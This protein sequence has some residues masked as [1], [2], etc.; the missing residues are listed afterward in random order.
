MALGEIMSLIVLLVAASFPLA[1]GCSVWRVFNGEA[2]N[3]LR[4]TYA[5]SLQ[6]QQSQSDQFLHRCGGTL[7][8]R[9]L[10]LTA[11]HCVWLD[12]V[13][14]ETDFRES[15]TY[16]GNLSKPLYAAVA[17]SCRHEEGWER[18]SVVRYYIPPTYWGVEPTKR[19][20]DI[21]VLV[22]ERDVRED[23]YPVIMQ[24]KKQPQNR[25]NSDEVVIIG[26]GAQNEQE[27]QNQKMYAENMPHLKS[28]NFQLIECDNETLISMG[29]SESSRIDFDKSMLC[30]VSDKTDA[31]D[32]CPGDSGGPLLE[33]H[34]H[35]PNQD[36]QIAVSMWAPNL[37]CS[38]ASRKPSVFTKVG[39]W[40]EAIQRIITRES[41]AA[42]K[43]ARTLGL[44]DPLMLPD[45]EHIQLQPVF[46]PADIF[47]QN[48]FA[49]QGNETSTDESNY[50]N[51]N[52]SVTN[53]Q[54]SLYQDTVLQNTSVLNLSTP[55]YSINWY[56]EFSSNNLYEANQTSVASDNTQYEQ[57]EL[58]EFRTRQYQ[59]ENK[60]SQFSTLFQYS[61]YQNDAEMSVSGCNNSYLDNQDEDNL[62]EPEPENESL[63]SENVSQQYENQGNLYQI[64][65]D[66]YNRENISQLNVHNQNE[67]NIYDFIQTSVIAQQLIQQQINQ[68]QAYF[69][70]QNENQQND[71]ILSSVIA[72]QQ[73]KQKGVDNNETQQIYQQYDGEENQ[74]KNKNNNKKDQEDAS[75]TSVIAQSQFK[76][77]NGAVGR[78][79]DQNGI[80]QQNGP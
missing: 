71:V 45:F 65:D 5:I 40:V 73:L 64:F 11:A 15:D 69:Y 22:L 43:S 38:G 39:P 32:I 79:F 36:I 54:G 28:S 76:Q 12:S 77:Y 4:Y 10:V 67:Q 53:Q 52:S 23:M 13:G 50:D 57:T 78:W 9:N 34:P 24:I 44:E 18:L 48:L 49:F 2:A 7:I 21:A 37:S 63:K 75:Q 19:G 41:G 27:T 74:D 58:T 6:V 60:D 46:L 17:P 26:W 61:K 30:A 33:L 35:D 14:G 70:E 59:L 8:A 51:Q 56:E 29:R 31:A 80:R 25:T 55:T 16:Q 1:Q 66:Y 3:V 47:V 72:R 68:E 20:Q 42:Y 62:Y